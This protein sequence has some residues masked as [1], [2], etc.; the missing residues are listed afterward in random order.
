LLHAEESAATLK[1]ATK[2]EF[3]ER[4]ACVSNESVQ[5]MQ[6]ARKSSSDGATKEREKERERFEVI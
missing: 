3:N 1:A 2:D 6:M 4:R 5:L